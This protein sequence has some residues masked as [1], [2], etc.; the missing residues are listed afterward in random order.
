M[1]SST[2]LHPI[3][4]API[5]PL[6]YRKD[7]RA[8]W[9]I[10]GGSESAGDGS[11]GDAGQGTDDQAGGDTGQRGH[12]DQQGQ[13]DQR[14]TFDAKYVEGLRTESARYRTQ[15]RELQ[16]AQ[17]A[18]TDAL[19]RALG[20]KSDDD[21]PDAAKLTEQ[22]TAAQAEARTL[23]VE[24]AIDKAARA[25]SADEDLLTAVL[26]HR[27]DLAKLDPIADDFAA[28]VDALVKATVD[29]NPK[30]KAGRVPGASG[31]DHAGGSGEQHDPAAS[32]RPGV[33]RIRAAY[34]AHPA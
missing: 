16:Q 10:L 18:Q 6:G 7:G 23:K 20:F 1:S 17:Q 27:G 8:I 2:L 25:H 13:D 29:S 14:Q 5:V 3:T 33:A 26:A 9:P 15:L 11:G 30:L 12:Q 19:A 22:V 24:R 31:A 34:D 32:A 4:R 28:Q 21:K